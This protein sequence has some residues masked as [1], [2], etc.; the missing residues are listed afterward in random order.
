MSLIDVRC[1]AGNAVAPYMDDLARL[2]ISIFR[3][4]PYLYEGN[5]SFEQEYL[6]TY[7]RSWRSVVVLAF[8]GGRVVGASTG[9]PLTD[10]I[11]AFREPF[12]G[13]V[14][15]AN[16]VFYCGESILLPAYRGRGIGHRFF[17]ERE[18]HARMLGG[19]HWTAFCVV[20]RAADDP[21]RPPFQRELEPFWTKRGYKPRPELKVSL[22]WPEVGQGEQMHTMT[23]WM[24]SLERPR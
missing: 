20:D 18:A 14:I 1:F 5:A 12:R 6:E 8:D 3:Q 17:H 2:R 10:E 9:V 19:M 22:S 23:Y 7:L 11:A 15:D 16:E 4:W 21:R 24:R 13:G